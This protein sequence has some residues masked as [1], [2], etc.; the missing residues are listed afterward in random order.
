MGE[1][2]KLLAKTNLSEI[3]SYVGYYTLTL[4]T[5]SMPYS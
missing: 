5:Q 1:E 3:N 2:I 4:K